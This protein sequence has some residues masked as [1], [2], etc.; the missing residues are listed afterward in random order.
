MTDRPAP[1]VRLRG[2]Y[3]T[4]LTAW[5]F[6]RDTP[7]TDPSAT[8]ERR[9]DR[10]FTDSLRTVALEDSW[11]RT[12]VWLTGRD[13]KEI[14]AS[15]EQLALDA[16]RWPADSS[17]GAVFVGQ[18][19]DADGGRGATVDLGE[20][21]RGFLPYD[22]VDGYVSAGDR[23]VL[24]VRQPAA[25]WLD[26]LPLVSP[27]LA[28]TCRGVSAAREGEN[29]GNGV[30]AFPEGW[31]LEEVT[32][33]LPD[34]VLEEITDRI[35][36]LESTVPAGPTGSP[37]KVAELTDTWWVCFG[38]ETRE[39]LDDYRRSVCATLP[40][41]HQLKLAANGDERAVDFVEVLLDRG[42]VD[43]PE[44]GAVV[45]AGRQTFGPNV[46]DEVALRHGKPAGHAISL[47]SATVIDTSD[48]GETVTIERS[49]AGGGTYDGLDT[50]IEA[51]D[52]AETVC[53]DGRWW[54]P[55][56]YRAADGCRKG[57]YVNICTP[58]EILP[59]RIQYVDLH[60]DV[61]KRP[62]GTVSVL[63]R[64]ELAAAVEA[65]HVR[66]E[67][68]ERARSVASSVAE[69]IAAE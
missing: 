27:H 33:T 3:S 14:A 67:L 16:F 22:L 24:Q 15:L 17:Q 1:L 43:H 2:I 39:R 44:H 66:P 18:V 12:G 7:V 29:T 13:A 26:R 45:E 30:T 68:A 19:S 32:G 46:G 35:R 21:R 49:M 20:G 37:R 9:F 38:R 58:L 56:T 64:D 23:Y 53:R 59:D 34:S 31:V 8:I 65:D 50:T 69:G 10:E 40:A 42:A 41:H 54:Y 36:E 48:D 47:G 51:G 5:C 25:P 63:D 60:V 61:V 55:T 62:D 6:D 4:A 11:D 28:V 52:T 57:T